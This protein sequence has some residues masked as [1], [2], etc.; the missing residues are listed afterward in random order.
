MTTDL[1]YLENTYLSN[2]EAVITDIVNTEKGIAILLNQTIFY[3]Q[4]GGQPSDQGTITSIENADEV[5]N[6]F[7]VQYVDGIVYHFIKEELV[8]LKVGDKINLAIDKEYRLKNAKSHTAGHLLQA[9]V[10]HL[11]NQLKAVKGYHFLDG[12]YVQFVGVKP[13]NSD[14]LL[15]KIN[16][17]LENAIKTGYRID[18]KMMS[19]TEIENACPNLPYA[20][21]EGKPLRVAEI[22]EI[23]FP[24]PC[25]GTHINSLAEFKFVKATKINTKKGD[26]KI[27]YTFA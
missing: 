21:P 10:G 24:V 22:I 4:G 7:F 15:E 9:V 18:T 5:Y 6:V 19:K 26:V 27:S 12:S 23:G 2:G 13:E 16:E 8:K 1:L 14:M 20:L 3:P 25:G 17:A 11:A